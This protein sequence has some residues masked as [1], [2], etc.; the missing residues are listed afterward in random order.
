MIKSFTIKS[1]HQDDLV[2]DLYNP[3]SLQV[4][5]VSGL[6][7]PKADIKRTSLAVMDGSQV[8]LIR[9]PERNI[10]MTM[11]LL[12]RNIEDARREIYEHFPAKGKVNLTVE[13][14]R[15]R[16]EIECLV[17]STEVDIFSKMSTA[18][19]SLICPTPWF[20]LVGSGAVQETS[21][22]GIE[23]GFSFPWLNPVNDTTIEFSSIHRAQENNVPYSGDVPTGVTISITASATI[24]DITIH[25]TGTNQMMKI[26]STMIQTLTGSKIS[27]SDQLIITTLQGK[28]SVYLVRNGVRTNVLNAVAP[29]SSWFTLTRGDNLFAFTATEGELNLTF[30]VMN[31][32]LFAGV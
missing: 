13:T 31:N 23:S 9:A 20:Y 18:V 17:E 30:S 2:L 32:V 22:S 15:R 28:K 27:A 5:S 7:P 26:S 29:D 6:A 3:E 19:V 4:M 1:P 16:L 25:N 24:G 12:G 11:A 8:S 21:F 10:V 14:T